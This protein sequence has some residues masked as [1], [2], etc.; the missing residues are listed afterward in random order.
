MTSAHAAPVF[1]FF[2]SF[3]S[4]GFRSSSAFSYSCCVRP[5]HWPDRAG[6]LA[7]SSI[8]IHLFSSSSTLPVALEQRPASR[9]ADSSKAR[10]QRGKLRLPLLFLAGSILSALPGWECTRRVKAAGSLGR[11]RPLLKVSGTRAV[12]APADTS[13]S[14]SH[15]KEK[16]I[17]RLR[18]ADVRTSCSLPQETE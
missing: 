11:T 4:S 12:S 3:A 7:H 5:V 9:M 14:A 6:R 8:D 13:S 10:S 16:R 1:S 15:R 17:T 2:F 18:N